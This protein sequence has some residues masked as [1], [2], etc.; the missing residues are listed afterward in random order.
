MLWY[1]GNVLNTCYFYLVCS[2]NSLNAQFMS[3]QII[4]L[5]SKLFNLC[6]SN[7]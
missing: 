1:Q 4:R 6:P 2:N 3:P 7:Y 5:H